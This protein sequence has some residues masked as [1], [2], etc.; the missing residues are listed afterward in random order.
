MCARVNIRL[1]DYASA[2]VPACLSRRLYAV[3]MKSQ[4]FDR[5]LTKDRRHYKSQ[6]NRKNLMKDTVPGLSQM[7]KLKCMTLEIRKF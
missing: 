1:F 3:E 4:H 2:S 7:S 6:C 5:Y